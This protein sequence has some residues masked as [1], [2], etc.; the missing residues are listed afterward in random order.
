MSGGAAGKRPLA[1]G[2][3][4]GAP[5]PRALCARAC[6]QAQWAGRAGRARA[7]REGAARLCPSKSSRGARARRRGGAAARRPRAQRVGGSG[8]A[9]RQALADD[10]RR[11]ST[12]SA[13]L[14]PPDSKRAAQK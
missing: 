3:G 13:K 2:D 12:K 6:V 5:D 1:A 10:G 9:D 11:E 7:R 4:D 8:C 14:T